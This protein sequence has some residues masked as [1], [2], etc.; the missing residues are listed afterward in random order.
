[1]NI[2]TG[3]DS[4]GDSQKELITIV[5]GGFDPLHAGH[6]R[7]IQGAARISD[8]GKTVLILNSD[9]WLIKKKGY[10]FQ[11]FMVRREILEE[12]KSVKC[13]IPQ[14][15]D[16]MTVSK[17]L[18]YLGAIYNSHSLVFCKGGDRVPGENVPEELVCERLGIR[19]LGG[20]GGYNKVDSSR[21]LVKRVAE[22]GVNEREKEKPD[23]K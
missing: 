8:C 15:D 17:T 22:H 3:S 1:M 16:D 20:I 23:G 12:L 13:I 14:I 11:N 6:I 4:R 10:V 7:Y 5:S 9:K 18:E 19:V 21:E 2:S